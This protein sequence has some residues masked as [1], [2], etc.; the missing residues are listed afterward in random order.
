MPH[1]P[2][3]LAELSGQQ[4]RQGRL[5]AAQKTLQVLAKHHPDDPRLP[6]LRA[7]QAIATGDVAE[8]ERIYAAGVAAR[9]GDEQLRLRWVRCL[10][11]LDRQ[12]EAQTV[13]AE[14]L[15]L[16]P[17]SADLLAERTLLYCRMR[18]AEAAQARLQTLERQ[19]SDHPLLP[20]LRQMAKK[21][22]GDAPT[23]ERTY[24]AA[25][26]AS[27]R[28][29]AARLRLVRHLR[30]LG[31][32][33]EALSVL[34]DGLAQTPDSAELL[35]QQ[36]FLLGKT[37]LLEAA[38]A[39][40]RLL[41][42][43]HPDHPQISQFRGTQAEA[44]GDLDEAQRIFAAD[45][46]AHPHDAA[47]RVR[48][49]NS[50]RKSGRIEDALEILAGQAQPTTA[51]RK[52]GIECL[53]EAGQWE[54]VSGLLDCWPDT[55]R[56]E[57]WLVKMRLRMRLAILRFEHG[58]A[59]EHAKAMLAVAPDNASAGIGFTRAAAAA[60]QP[61]LAWKA[62]VHIPRKSPNGGPPRRGAG[63]LR[64]LIGQIVNDLRLRPQETAQLAAAA[65][66]GTEALIETAGALLR[67]GPGNFAAALGLLIGLARAGVFTPPSAGLQANCRIPKILHQFWDTETPPR[68]VDLLMERAKAVNG[69]LS[70]RRWNDA[71][72]RRFLS[73]F[74]RPEPL[75][76]YKLARHPAMKAD[77]FRLAVLYA[78]GGVY[79][80]A[81]DY[82]AAPLSTLLSPDVTFCCY[83]DEFCSIGNNFLAATPRHPLTG[84]A[85]REAAQSVIEGA[86]ESLW[87]VTGPGL[88]SRVV[89]NSIAWTPDLRPSPGL[90]VLPL[91]I[92]H[93]VVHPHRRV[94][95]KA[96]ARHWIRAA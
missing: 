7:A 54:E 81:D 59:L 34:S 47:R 49:T 23:T 76:A 20:R 2:R 28:N 38:Q 3:L 22:G 89:A 40:L 45:A 10:L 95:Y 58:T 42:A 77:L 94:S 44:A 66:L 57:D 48:W 6:Q 51:E 31:R 29:I 8:A 12:I 39:S 24:A 60:F 5:Q 78:E 14:G 79:L 1:A 75:R 86:T 72:V 17:A 18:Q 68:D 96:D 88:M 26:E 85:L 84:A 46:A 82:C 61:E 65:E 56:P 74:G 67:S 30:G 32:Y 21:L 9:P 43:H 87:L 37:G 33:D 15:A 92:F 19:A 35:A 64:S 91:R 25:V 4:R 11:R 50:L 36:T 73:A 90:T 63:A 80:D 52:L 83:Q 71:A 70:Y 93:G 53:L 55:G 41:A 62:L 13:L 69:D 16:E 27:P